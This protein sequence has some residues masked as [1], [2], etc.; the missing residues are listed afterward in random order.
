MLQRMM[1]YGGRRMEVVC[2]SK[3]G[4]IFASPIDLDEEH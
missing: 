2:S 3:F 1:D 4:K